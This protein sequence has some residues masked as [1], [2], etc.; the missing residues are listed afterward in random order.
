MT[1]Y[2]ITGAT[3]S[4][5][6]AVTELVL[7]NTS[8]S[9]YLLLRAASDEQLSER[10]DSLMQFWEFSPDNKDICKR[11]TPLRG[12]I[13]LPNFGLAENVYT[14]LANHCTHIIHCAGVVRMNLPIEDAR[15]AAVGSAK[16]I[17]Q[18][19]EACQHHGHL[20][21][22][23]FVS[24]VG[25]GGRNTGVIPEEW[26]KNKRDFHNTYEQSKAEA[27]EYI[28]SKIKDGLPVTIHRPSMV[29]GDSRTGKIIHFQIFYHICEFL[30]GKRTFGVLPNIG[31]TP[32]DIIPSDYVAHAIVWSSQQPDTAGRILHLCSGPDGAILLKQLAARLQEVLPTTGEK[33]PATI[34]LPVWLFRLAIPVISV[35]SPPR[36]RRALGTLPIFLDYLSEEQA[37][38]ND[39]TC[40][41][42]DSA[43]I[44][45]PPVDTYL[46]TL[47][48]YYLSH[49]RKK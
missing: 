25:V 41:L 38:G 30:S 24:T 5:G 45:L 21:K 19:A 2:F 43:G 35:F 37:F 16:N 6:S 12:D 31:D 26:I 13:S 33:L 29:V 46:E 7:K 28:A 23:E 15:N 42:L 17:I 40:Q 49:R 39:K 47:L 18:L 34:T 36:L 48:S 14:G 8:A 32:L 11:I 3:G 9:V 20:K 44:R 4:V 22:V 1:T 27:E 10:I